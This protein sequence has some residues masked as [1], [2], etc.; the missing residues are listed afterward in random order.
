MKPRT[1]L[2]DFSIIWLSLIGLTLIALWEGLVFAF[3]IPQW[4]LPAPSDIGVE[5]LHS[6][7]LLIFH[8]WVTLQEIIIGFSVALSTGVFLAILI[9]YYRAV[10]RLVYP[11]V[12]AS[13]TIPIIVIAPLLLIWV[14]YGLTPKIIVVTLV[15]F[16]PIVV[17][18]VDGL[19]SVDLE[20]INLMRTL[21]ATRWQIFTKIQIPSSLPFLFSGMKVGATL[22][23][24][25]AVI[26]EWVG[27]NAGL[28]YLTRMSVPLFLTSRSFAAVLILSVLGVGIFLLASLLER[29]LLPWHHRNNKMNLDS[30]D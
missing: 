30:K 10:G 8:T 3:D 28:G 25:G 23:V 4:K 13:Q 19:R 11:I 9:S 7:N 20:M 22:S 21:G 14:G 24:I 29:A 16:F 12:I 18:T 17:N 1:R 6:K 26:G 2:F 27:S 15:A 5:L